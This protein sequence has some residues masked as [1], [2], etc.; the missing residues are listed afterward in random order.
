MPGCELRV[1]RKAFLVRCPGVVPGAVDGGH[2]RQHDIQLA[3]QG[4]S[5]QFE[6][7]PHV[8]EAADRQHLGLRGSPGHQAQVTIVNPCP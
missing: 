3:C 8:V 5:V 7:A 4:I 2:G 1:L 6:T